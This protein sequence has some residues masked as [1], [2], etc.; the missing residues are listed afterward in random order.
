MPQTQSDLIVAIV[1]KGSN[2]ELVEAAKKAGAQG[3]TIIYGRGTGLHDTKRLLGIPIEPEKDI[4]L[5]VV[6]RDIT[7]RV[8]DA[9]VKE[10][11]LDKPNTGI[12]FVME[13]SKVVGIAHLLEQ[14]QS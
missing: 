9:I 14:N 7:D 13:L 8:L 12:A 6:N 3:A 4:I 11:H 10:G 5:I 1:K 2:P